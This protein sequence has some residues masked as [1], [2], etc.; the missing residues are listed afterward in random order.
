M[1]RCTGD[2]GQAI[3]AVAFVLVLLVVSLF[4]LARVARAVADRGRARTAADAA[5]LAGVYDGEPAAREMA[6]RNGGRLVR[7]A[8]AGHQVEVTV[9]IGEMSAVARAE[10]DAFRSEVR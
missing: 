10:L 2:R 8:R 7:F 6:E 1:V 5:A 4:V 3:P 9:E